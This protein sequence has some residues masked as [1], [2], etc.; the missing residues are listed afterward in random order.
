MRPP[1]TWRP[2]H[3]KGV[4]THMEK[5]VE[6]QRVRL[7]KSMLEQALI[8][9]LE[10][11]PLTDIEVAELCRAAGINR[12]TF[13]SHYGNPTDLFDEVCGRKYAEIGSLLAQA[14][15]GLPLPLARR[16]EIICTY[17]RDHERLF[18]AIFSSSA[19]IPAWAEAFFDI[20]DGTSATGEELLAGYDEQT[21]RLLHTYLTHGTYSLVRQWLLEDSSKTPHELGELAQLIATHGWAGAGRR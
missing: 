16:V 14:S 1:R 17:L 5:P 9:L 13:Y 6:N 12:T 2:G 11:K 7:T 4:R 8:G 15:G 3:G 19:E 10:T 20:P 21:R 18:R